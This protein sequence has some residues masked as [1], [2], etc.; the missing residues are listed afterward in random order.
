MI[1]KQKEKVQSG[2]KTQT[3]RVAKAG[4]TAHYWQGWHEDADVVIRSVKTAKGHQ[5]WST[6]GE[7]PAIPKMYQ[8]A[9]GRICI[10]A[11]RLE[12]LHEIDEHDARA[13]GVASVEE[14]KA[15]WESINGKTKGARWND[16]P[17]VWVIEFMYLGDV[18]PEAEAS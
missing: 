6:A 17:L 11:I 1:F 9:F 14:Y 8:K 18:A 10:T 16:N 13:E 2:E 12:G 15:L 4:E 3:R 7:Y 5:K